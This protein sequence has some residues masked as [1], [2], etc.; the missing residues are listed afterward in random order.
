MI[1]HIIYGVLFLCISFVAFHLIQY[2][3]D[4]FT[5]TGDKK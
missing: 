4:N 3:Y 1:E 2:K 5:E